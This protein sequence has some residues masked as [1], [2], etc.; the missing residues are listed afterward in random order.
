MS[1]Y[2]GDSSAKLARLR[3]RLHKHQYLLLYDPIQSRSNRNCC[4]VCHNMPQKKGA[5][6]V[7]GDEELGQRETNRNWFRGP[8]ENTNAN[9]TGKPSSPLGHPSE[10]DRSRGDPQADRK[11]MPPREAK[12]NSVKSFC[13]RKRWGLQTWILI[14]IPIIV[15]IGI[16]IGLVVWLSQRGGSDSSPSPTPPPSSPSSPLHGVLSIPPEASE[17]PITKGVNKVKVNFTVSNQDLPDSH[18]LQSGYYFG[19]ALLPIGDLDSDGRTEVIISAS[20]A[21]HKGQ[22]QVGWLYLAFMGKGPDGTGIDVDFLGSGTTAGERFG[23]SLCRWNDVNNDGIPEVVVG[24][25]TYMVPGEPSTMQTGAIYIVEI[26]G[27][28]KAIENMHRITN[29]EGGLSANDIPAK[30]TFGSAVASMDVNGD[31]MLEI[32]VGANDADDGM[33][34][35]YV[36]FMNSDFTVATKVQIRPL[37][38]DGSVLSYLQEGAQLGRNLAALGEFDIFEGPVLASQVQNGSAN[39]IAKTAIV[40]LAIGPDGGLLDGTSIAGPDY[41]NYG[42]ALAALGDLDNDG[43]TEL[44]VGANIYQSKAWVPSTLCDNCGAVEIV[45]LDKNLEPTEVN[46]ATSNSFI[47]KNENLGVLQELY[48]H[49]YFGDAIA[50]LGDLNDDGTTDLMVSETHYNGSPDDGAFDHQGRVHVLL[51]RAA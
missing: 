40:L 36:L 44:G 22:A 43:N 25:H 38:E 17:E 12:D 29:G 16:G 50:P 7:V 11:D 24:A 3:P 26:N 10:S 31:D 45:F 33:G 41:S 39:G 4:A 35:I 2:N 51:L 6:K 8:R 18:Q 20:H 21:T 32:F 19:H 14:M 30:S 13:L 37:M 9:S 46:F 49:C 42:S 34:I 47:G 5:D 1:V 28:D 15:G 48:T 27:E 23:I